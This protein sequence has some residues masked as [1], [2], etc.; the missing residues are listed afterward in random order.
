[1]VEPDLP[2]RAARWGTDYRPLHGHTQSTAAA[3]P[4]VI[5]SEQRTM[6]GFPRHPVARR[7]RRGPSQQRCLD[8]AQKRRI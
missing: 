7:Y 3:L 6:S 8:N 1:M 4:K 2:E 5:I